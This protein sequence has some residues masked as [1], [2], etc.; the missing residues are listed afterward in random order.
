[1]NKGW[2]DGRKEGG[3]EERQEYRKEERQEYRMVKER[4]LGHSG[5]HRNVGMQEKRDTGKARREGK[6]RCSNRTWRNC[7][8]FSRYGTQCAGS[9]HVPRRLTTVWN[10]S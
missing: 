4:V 8:I 1:M 6:L 2:K 5:G 9:N 10:I 3:K 7:F